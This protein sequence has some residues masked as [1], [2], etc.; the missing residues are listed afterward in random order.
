MVSGAREP[1][2]ARVLVVDDNPAIHDDFRKIF[3]PREVPSALDDLEEALFGGRTN[4]GSPAAVELSFAHQG[5]EA[6]ALVEA[7]LAE[8]RTFDVAFVDVRMPPGIDG[9]ETAVRLWTLDRRLQ[10]VLCTAYSDYSWEEI[11]DRLGAADGYLILKKPFDR[12]EA[13]QLVHS[14][15]EKRALFNERDMRLQELDR[16]IRERTAELATANASLALEMT[17]RLVTEQQLHQLQKLEALGR[18]AACMGHEINNPLSYVLGNVE[19]A[20]FM[21]EEGSPLGLAER[22]ELRTMLDEAAAGV[23]RIA[24]LVRH[25]KVFSRSERQPAQAFRVNDVVESALTLVDNEIRHRATLVR[26]L[27]ADLPVLM[28]E[29][30]RVETVLVNL[31]LNAVQ[32]ISPGDPAGNRIRVSTRRDSGDEIVIDVS[33]SGRGI[34]QDELERVFE[35]FYTTKPVGEGTGL[36]LAIC[37]TIIQAHGGRLSIA[38]APGSGTTVTAVLP[39]SSAAVG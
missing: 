37:H 6:L 4:P 31:L 18:L 11:A 33:D 19:Q 24:V 38:S 27:A 32:A 23:H 30:Q 1:F 29:P 3:A 9:V 34:P 25:L 39:I 20:G 12:V 7:E 17:Q 21:L 2:A 14:L 28:G 15:A 22:G 36:G 10:I 16:L 13:R 5:R 8:G 35:A 26:D